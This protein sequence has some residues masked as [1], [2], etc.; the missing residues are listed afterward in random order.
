MKTRRFSRFALSESG[1]NF[2]WVL[3]ARTRTA[4]VAAKSVETISLKAGEIYRLE[5]GLCHWEIEVLSGC[6]W[7][8]QAGVSGDFIFHAGQNFQSVNEGL[9][10]IEAMADSSAALRIVTPT[11]ERLE[12]A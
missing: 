9:I 6:V 12:A 11:T 5:P 7:I 2:S 1:F 10:V 8:T 3:P 4:C